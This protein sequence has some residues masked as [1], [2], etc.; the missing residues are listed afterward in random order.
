MRSA[1]TL[2]FVGSEV[3]GYCRGGLT[4]AAPSMSERDGWTASVGG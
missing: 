4:A 2:A 1:W 3:M